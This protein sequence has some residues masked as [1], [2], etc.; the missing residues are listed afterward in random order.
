MELM[1]DTRALSSLSVDQAL[2][3]EGAASFGAPMS[4]V[5]GDLT[6]HGRIIGGHLSAAPPAVAAPVFYDDTGRIALPRATNR[7]TGYLSADDFR[8]F[9]AKQTS[10]GFSGADKFLRGDLT[11]ATPPTPGLAAIPRVVTVGV[12]APSIQACI[13][14]CVNPSA[15]A[16]WCVRIPPGSGAGIGVQ[17]LRLRGC[18]ALEGMG[19][20]VIS[21][22]HEFERSATAANNKFECSNL[23]FDNAQ[24]RF[25][26]TSDVTTAVKFTHCSVS[27]SGGGMRVIFVVPNAV[28]VYM[29]YCTLSILPPLGGGTMFEL[30]GGPFSVGCGVYLTACRSSDSALFMRLH[31]PDS[32][33]VLDGCSVSCTEAIAQVEPDCELT[34]SNCTLQTSVTGTC[35]TVMGATAKFKTFNCT[36][37]APDLPSAFVVN[38]TGTFVT[39]GTEV[40]SVLSNTNNTYPRNTRLGEQVRLQ[41]M[42]TTLAVIPYV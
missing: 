11:W 32:R 9:A 2:Q 12:D 30:L 14:M 23:Q 42:A 21:G 27:N 10:L 15:A 37:D 35:V 25:T 8:E 5:H 26:G 34:A 36:L 6:V 1:R 4:V 7:V 41:L 31:V 17:N 39:T 20:S 16:P 38:G 19:L 29:D 28:S 13:D 18:V 33:A 22:E 3:V 40:G 24:F